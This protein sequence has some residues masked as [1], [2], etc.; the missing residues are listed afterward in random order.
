MKTGIQILLVPS[1]LGRECIKKVFL[2]GQSVFLLGAECVFLL[3]T[4][5]VFLLGEESVFLL[6][7]ERE[8]CE[9]VAWGLATTL[10]IETMLVAGEM[11]CS[12]E[13]PG[14]NKEAIN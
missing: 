9:L 5:S 14:L 12:E 2:L 3:G 13:A 6:G 4:E 8:L 7:S 11:H 10:C 1:S